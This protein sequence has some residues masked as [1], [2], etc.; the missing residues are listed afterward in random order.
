M[1]FESKS[2][3][4]PFSEKPGNYVYQPEHMALLIMKRVNEGARMEFKNCVI[5][6][7][8]D[9]ASLSFYQTNLY[10]FCMAT[11][12]FDHSKLAEG[13]SRKVCIQLSW[14]LTSGFREE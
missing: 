11:M 1:S 8:S 12:L 10:G 9:A 5:L 14:N 2:S 6:S 13:H 7:F 4:Y 3:I